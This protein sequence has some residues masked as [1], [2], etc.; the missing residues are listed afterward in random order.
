VLTIV[1]AIRADAGRE[2]LAACDQIKGLD[3]STLYYGATKSSN[4][5]CSTTQHVPNTL[6]QNGKITVL[7]STGYE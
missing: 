7:K 5:L 3:E 1:T 2:I 4:G 6:I